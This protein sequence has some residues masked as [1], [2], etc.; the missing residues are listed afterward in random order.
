[1]NIVDLPS[2]AV[3]AVVG[4]IA[5][6]A[7]EATAVDRVAVAIVD[8]AHRAMRVDRVLRAAD[9]DTKVDRATT[10][11][12]VMNTATATVAVTAK[13]DRVIRMH[14]IPMDPSLKDNLGKRVDRA[15][16]ADHAVIIRVARVATTED[17]VVPVVDRDSRSAKAKAAVMAAV[18]VEDPILAKAAMVHAAMDRARKVRVRNTAVA[19]AQPPK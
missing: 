8:L 2:V 6:V 4:R 11:D 16:K 3:T 10:E 18:V 14:Q 1:M 12:P 9:R 5:V 7:R 15:K 13:M 17:R 19:R